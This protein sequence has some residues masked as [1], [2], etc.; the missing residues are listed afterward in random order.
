MDYKKHYDKLM[1]FRL[2]NPPQ[3]VYTELHHIIPKCMGGS[4]EK[5]NLVR[6]TAREH[7]LAHALL[8]KHYKTS[9]LAHAW[10]CMLRFDRN[11]ERFFTARQYEMARKA[12]SNTLKITMKGEGNSFYGKT[13][14]EETKT[15]LSER[16]KEWHKHNKK[17]EDIIEN[18]VDKVASKPASEKQKQVVS[19]LGKNKITLK[20]IITGE[21]VRVDKSLKTD[22]DSN[23]WKNP[24]AIHQ[25]RE[26]CIHCGVESV[27]GN[28]KRWHNDNCK[29]KLG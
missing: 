14:S 15:L 17:A 12:H 18:W 13:H 1:E 24:A 19:D 22:Y 7:Y 10:F 5:D 8:F 16:N 2:N 9:K 11:Q 6:L 29:A 23:I 4:D 26:K 21:C 27:A 20:N 28:I 25:K 3:N